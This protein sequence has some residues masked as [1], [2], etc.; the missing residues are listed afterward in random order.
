ME[1][2]LAV[3]MG[4]N[5]SQS[6]GGEGN[7]HW[8]ELFRHIQRQEPLQIVSQCRVLKLISW[9]FLWENFLNSECQSFAVNVAELSAIM[10]SSLIEGIEK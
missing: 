8:I 3:K 1:G 7:N 6:E 4:V 10:N 9:N 2:E 5:V